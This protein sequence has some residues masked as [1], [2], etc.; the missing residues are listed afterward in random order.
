MIQ[1]SNMTELES[2]ENYEMYS[3]NDPINFATN[4]QSQN[5][6]YQSMDYPPNTT[7][8]Y[9]PNMQKIPE[10]PVVAPVKENM[11]LTIRPEIRKGCSWEINVRFSEELIEEI[12][13]NEVFLEKPVTAGYHLCMKFRSKLITPIKEVGFAKVASMCTKTKSVSVCSNVATIKVKFNARPR[14]V[15]RKHSDMLILVVT[16]KK[17]DQA[18]ATTCQELIFR[19]GTGSEYSAESRK[20]AALLENNKVHQN[21]GNYF[22]VPNTAD[23]GLWP[24][25][26][27]SP[28]YES[29]EANQFIS[30]FI[31]SKGDALIYNPNVMNSYSAPNYVQPEM[32]DLPVSTLTNVEVKLEGHNSNKRKRED[33][34]E[35]S[36]KRRRFPL[37][38]K[39]YQTLFFN[40]VHFLTLDEIKIVCRKAP[41]PLFIKDENS[42]YLY[43]NPAFCSFIM[44]VSETPTIINR[45]TNQ[46]LDERDAARVMKQDSQLMSSTEGTT[47]TFEVH[48]KK[49]EYRVMKQFTTLR[50]GCKVIIGAVLF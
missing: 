27:P 3:Q 40:T 29:I 10:A 47:R 25:N 35:D 37:E 14:A 1:L 44:D 36:T 8:M 38:T 2:L 22:Q 31:A 42:V 43:I 7:M 4:F 9:N 5:L 21:N 50:D 6:Y 12:G 33:L 23:G 46:I 45:S 16:L 48:L 41:I 19:G 24:V 39:Y 34:E 15:F 26:N 30:N 20:K 28:L 17:G 49:E 11:M 18:I 13:L 32:Q